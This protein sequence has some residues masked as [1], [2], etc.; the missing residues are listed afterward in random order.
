MMSIEPNKVPF[1][2]PVECVIADAFYV[3]LNMG[4]NHILFKDLSK[5]HVHYSIFHYGTTLDFHK[6]LE[7]ESNPLK[8]YPIQIKKELDFQPFIE[9]IAQDMI[10]N[11][12]ALVKMNSSEF[13]DLEVKFIP[14]TGLKELF[15]GLVK[16]NRWT[17][18]FEFFDDFDRAFRYAKLGELPESSPV[19]GWSSEGHFTLSCGNHGI[20][21]DTNKFSEIFEKNIQR[22]L[23]P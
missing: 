23:K 15:S 20:L 12:N 13:Q 9:R 3:R 18:S 6:T 8:R 21:F 22:S 1:P 4:R 2:K 5:N 14:M 17:F 7:T 11:R 19:M 10:A 16:S